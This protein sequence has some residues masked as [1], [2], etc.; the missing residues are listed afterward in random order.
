MQGIDRPEFARCLSCLE[1]FRQ[2]AEQ[3]TKILFRNPL[4][5]VRPATAGAHHFALHDSR[6]HGMT[7]DVIEVRAHVG[8]DL[9]SR[10]ADH[11]KRL[12]RRTRLKPPN[13]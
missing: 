3:R 6:V 2:A 9:F 5:M 7:G 1:N 8:K 12:P 10:A 13:T 4:E 11:E